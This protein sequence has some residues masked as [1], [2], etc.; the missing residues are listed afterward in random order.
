MP[1]GKDGWMGFAS[2][3]GWLRRM[4]KKDGEGFGFVSGKGLI[5]HG[6][7]LTDTDRHETT[8]HTEIH[9]KGVI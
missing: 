5:S 4:D 2:R 9:E 1:D 6:R 7:T 8:E 3:I